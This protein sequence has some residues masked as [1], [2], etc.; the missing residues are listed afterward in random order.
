MAFLKNGPKLSH[1]QIS[2]PFPNMY[3]FRWFPIISMVPRRTPARKQSLA[4]Q[5]RGP[6]NKS[7]LLVPPPYKCNASIRSVSTI[8]NG[9]PSIARMPSVM[10]KAVP[11]W[12][13]LPGDASK[14]YL[15][16]SGNTWTC[17]DCHFYVDDMIVIVFEVSLCFYR[18]VAV[19]S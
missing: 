14:G 10:T 13:G 7:F 17:L 12:T 3:R 16:S 18:V 9:T 4:F 6:A 2:L 1:K 5:W 19:L 11:P 15:V 8:A